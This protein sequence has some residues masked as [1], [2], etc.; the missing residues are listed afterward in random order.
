VEGEAGSSGFAVNDGLLFK[1]D[2]VN[3]K[4]TRGFSF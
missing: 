4:A 1:K 2:P 3:K